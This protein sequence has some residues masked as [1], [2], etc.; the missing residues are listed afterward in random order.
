[1]NKN[2]RRSEGWWGSTRLGRVGSQGRLF[3]NRKQ[4][5]IVKIQNRARRGEGGSDHGHGEIENPVRHSKGAQNR[6]IK[7]GRKGDI[8][9]VVNKLMRGG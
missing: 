1:M 8:K 3:E 5:R 9:R 2:A 7:G 4:G 6:L